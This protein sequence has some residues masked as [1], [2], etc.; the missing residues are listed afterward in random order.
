MNSSGFYDEGL[1]AAASGLR[2]EFNP[3]SA[4]TGSHENW[5]RGF[6]SY[7]VANDDGHV[8]EASLRRCSWLEQENAPLHSCPWAWCLIHGSAI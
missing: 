7:G 3:Y 4:G 5:R 1:V 2:A 8:A 6:V